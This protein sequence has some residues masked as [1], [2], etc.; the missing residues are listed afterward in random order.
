VQ[1]GNG[2]PAEEVMQNVAVCKCIEIADVTA[3]LES[4]QHGI[5]VTSCSIEG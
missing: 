4:L 5:E 3:C 1:G 2:I